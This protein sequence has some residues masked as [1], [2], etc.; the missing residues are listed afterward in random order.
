LLSFKV[1]RDGIYIAGSFPLEGTGSI[2]EALKT[3]PAQREF[4]EPPDG[5]TSEEVRWMLAMMDEHI[6]HMN[7]ARTQEIQTLHQALG[8]RILFLGDAA[9]AM[10]Q[11]LGQGATQAIEDAL[12]AAAVL[13]N[14]PTS[15]QTMSA[16][17]EARRKERVEFA[18]RFT[19]E[20]TDTLLA[21]DPV[22]GSLAKA[23][24]PF[25]SKLRK[26]YSDVA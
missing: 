4:F 25:L 11:T 24:Q 18:R 7:W 10:Y 5:K 20:A 1:P 6:H 13:R 3:A 22:E 8:G 26:L 23:Q 17:Y 19:R 21:T 9:H 2:P 14:H 15:P 16:V 12:A